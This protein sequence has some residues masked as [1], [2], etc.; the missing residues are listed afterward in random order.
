MRESLLWVFRRRFVFRVVG[1][2]MLPTLRPGDLVLTRPAPGA[3]VGDLIVCRHPIKSDVTIIKR[4]VDV[5][6]GIIV[7][8][9]NA[10]VGSDSRQFGAVPPDCILGIVTSLLR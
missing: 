5:Q 1:D 10:E 8:S 2:S 3:D 9:D 6:D 4:V 7:H